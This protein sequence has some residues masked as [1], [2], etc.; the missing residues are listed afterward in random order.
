MIKYYVLSKYLFYIYMTFNSVKSV[1]NIMHMY[2][3][4]LDD[5]LT[6]LV[7]FFDMFNVYFDNNVIFRINI[8]RYFAFCKTVIFIL[9]KSR[10]LI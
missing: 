1:H 9:F 7:T 6:M 3:Y 5:T 8:T 4:S 2:L 10:L